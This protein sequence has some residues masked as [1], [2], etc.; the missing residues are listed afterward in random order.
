MITGPEYSPYLIYDPPAT[1]SFGAFVYGAVVING[2]PV[3]GATITM[4]HNGSAPITATTMIVPE[5]QPAYPI[6]MFGTAPGDIS[7]TYGSLVN[8][9]ASY[10]DENSNVRLLNSG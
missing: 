2:V 8:I 1:P 7:A 3:S 9:T 4:T 10:V 5:I 6:Y